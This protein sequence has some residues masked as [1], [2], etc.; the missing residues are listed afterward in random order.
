MLLF[1][2]LLVFVKSVT[3]HQFV[4]EPIPKLQLNEVS[5]NPQDAFIEIKSQEDVQN[6]DNFYLV[7]MDFAPLQNKNTATLNVRA[8]IDLKGKKVHWKYVVGNHSV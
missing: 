1:F 3:S 4:E 8:L 7:I 5:T 2:F 6:L